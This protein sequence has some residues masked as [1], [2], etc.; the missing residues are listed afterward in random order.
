MVRLDELIA[1]PLK[2]LD[3]VVVDRAELGPQGAV[4]GDRSYALVE[5]GVDP[6]TA[7]VGGDGGYVNGKR[8]PAVHP[9][10][11]EY[12]LAGPP[13][14]TPTAVTIERPER[15]VDGVTV[16]AD[17]CR[18]DLRDDASALEA[19]IG[20]YL[21]YAVDLVVD[22]DGGFPDDRVAPGPTVVSQETLRAFASWFDE[23][24]D[25]TEARRRLRPNLVLAD[26][27]AFWED[28]LFADHGEGVRFTIGDVDLVGVNPCQRCV[29]PARHPDTGETIEGFRERFVSKRR[30]TRPEW[31][32]GNRFDHEFRLMINTVVPKRSWGSTVA[33]GS[34]VDVDVTVPVDDAEGVPTADTETA[35]STE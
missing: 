24:A 6:Q 17:T 23:I 34:G 2:S 29:V 12:E 35:Q 19:W 15:V 32:D 22:D 33:V 27:P 8:E 25:A 18:F 30:A 3:G 16:S 4:R 5:A 10:R 20:E 7:S 13:D 31:T 26:C 28:H 9:L 11:A 21:G 14:A 1:Y